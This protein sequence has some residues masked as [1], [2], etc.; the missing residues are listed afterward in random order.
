MK[1]AAVLHK[2]EQVQRSKLRLAMEGMVCQSITRERSYGDGDCQAWT[3]RKDWN[4]RLNEMGSLG[5]VDF[6]FRHL[7]QLN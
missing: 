2:K 1:L 7:S 5:I 3:G 4:A 6:L